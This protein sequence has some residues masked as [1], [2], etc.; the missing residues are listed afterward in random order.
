MG[1]RLILFLDIL[2]TGLVAGTIF[3]IWIGYNPQYLSAPAYVEQ[4]QGAINALNVLMPILGFVAIL[5]TVLSAILNR[6]N[7][8]VLTALL[9]ASVLLIGSGLVTRFGNQPING[10]VIQW[11]LTEIPANWTELRDQGGHSIPFGQ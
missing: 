10:I 4:Q 11:E 6:K 8:V 5:L 7:K 1:R 2:I 3:G 9:I